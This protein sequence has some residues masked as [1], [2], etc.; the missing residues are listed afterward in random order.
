MCRLLVLAMIPLFLATI[1]CTGKGDI[2]GTVSYRPASKKVA[3][4]TVMFIGADNQPRYGIINP[5]GTYLVRGVPSGKAKI[6]VASP[7]PVQPPDARG[8]GRVDRAQIGDR[9]PEGEGEP[10]ATATAQP[11]P[12]VAKSWFPIPEK[13]AE[14]DKSGLA[15]D[16][17]R[18]TNTFDIILD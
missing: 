12:E 7:N 1:G 5:D 17:K 8:A 14:P 3:F 18:G 15:F 10:S 13:Y 16:V 6:T 4:G 11:A 2:Q 9:K